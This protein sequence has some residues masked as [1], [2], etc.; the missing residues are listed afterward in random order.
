MP[1][2]GEYAGIEKISRLEID[3]LESGESKC[4]DDVLNSGVAIGGVPGKTWLLASRTT[5]D[6]G[7]VGS[8]DSVGAGIKG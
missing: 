1:W 3:A 2:V 8:M 6:S 5:S 7:V 4:V